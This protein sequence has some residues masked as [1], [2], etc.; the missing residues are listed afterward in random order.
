V[1]Q[2][3]K[4]EMNGLVR[5]VEQSLRKALLFMDEIGRARSK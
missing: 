3:S 1:A 5:A 2:E 4:G